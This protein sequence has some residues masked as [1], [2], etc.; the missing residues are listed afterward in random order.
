[1]FSISD[2]TYYLSDEQIF[3]IYTLLQMEDIATADVVLVLDGICFVLI[4]YL[5][6]FENINLNDFL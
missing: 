2:S 5:F 6:L 1:M 3:S 4:L